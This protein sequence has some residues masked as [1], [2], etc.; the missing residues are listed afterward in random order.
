MSNSNEFPVAFIKIQGV[1]CLIFAADT[2]TKSD[3]ARREALVRLQ[4]MARANGMIATKSALATTQNG[5]A[6]YFGSPDLVRY[7]SINGVPRWT[8]KLRGLG[9]L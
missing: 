8:H 1:S 7:L 3:S 4:V 6:Y 2:V 5:R 9:S